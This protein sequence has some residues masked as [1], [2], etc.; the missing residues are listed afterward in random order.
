MPS[1]AVT[2]RAA[3]AGRALITLLVAA[4]LAACGGDG[5]TDP[6]TDVV[7]GRRFALVS[8]D[9]APLPAPFAPAVERGLPNARVQSATLDFGGTGRATGRR[10]YVGDG[11]PETFLFDLGYRQDGAQVLIRMFGDDAPPDT[12]V[13][14]GRELRVR[15]Q[16]YRRADG[17]R[18]VVE[19]LYRE[20]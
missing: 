18:G 8:V 15:E 2:S 14:A 12:G 13:V 11:P 17:T 7:A 20:R 1:D 4:G 9:G 19:L 6:A 10:E 5:G 3:R 16:Y